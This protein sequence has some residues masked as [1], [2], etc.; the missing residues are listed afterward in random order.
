MEPEFLREGHAVDDTLAPDRIVVGC[1]SAEAERLL[2]ALYEPLLSRGIP[3]I[4]C[5]LE[6]AVVKVAANAF[7]ATKISFINAMAEVCEAAGANVEVLASALAP[8]PRIGGQFLKPGLGFGGG[9]LPKD[10]RAFMS[11]AG[12]IGAEQALTFLREVDDINR[13]RWGPGSRSRSAD[14]G[15]PRQKRH[16]RGPRCGI[17]TALGRHP[18]F[19]GRGSRICASH[20]RAQSGGSRPEGGTNARRAFPLLAFADS[21]QDA[22]FGSDLV[23]HLTEWPEYRALDPRELAR[24]ARHR[25]VIDGRGVLDEERW[26]AACWQFRALGRPPMSPV[27][28]P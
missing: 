28:G 18:R 4:S 1:E 22:V 23:M 21:A 16:G 25:V 3:W 7:L 20:P 6:T 27:E 5:D 10:I 15:R 8:D 11:R 19:A 24:T 2:K 13:R 17:Q 14:A 12:E 26:V 9:C